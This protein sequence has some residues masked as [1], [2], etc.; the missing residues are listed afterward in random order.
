MAVED[1]EDAAIAR[2]RAE[3]ER[4]LANQ[5]AEIRRRFAR[6][7][8]DEDGRLVNT[9]ANLAAA[10]AVGSKLATVIERMGGT[11]TRAFRSTVA[12]V[13]AEVGAELGELGIPDALSEVGEESLQAQ[14]GS[15]ID[16]IA[17]V[18]GEEARDA[19]RE[20]ITESIRGTVTPDAAIE[21]AMGVLGKS[22]ARVASLVDTGVMAADRGVVMAQASESGFTWF[23]LDGPSDSLTRPWCAERIGRRFTQEQIAGMSN[24]VG[25]NPPW[26]YAGGYGCRHRWTVIDV[27]ELDDWP[28][29]TA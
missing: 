22:A 4:T 18:T 7:K 15:L 12:A 11:G 17:T 5:E 14:F 25:P 9:D 13:L 27:S 29:G 10:L 20:A 16:D 28:A 19:L 2:L 3:L 23:V 8:R 1:I 6:L 21:A 24:D 26:L